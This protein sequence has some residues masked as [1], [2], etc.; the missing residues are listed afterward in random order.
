MLLRTCCER[1]KAKMSMNNLKLITTENFEE[2]TPCDFWADINNEY[3]LT[4]E[5]IGRALEYNNPSEAIK[6]IHQRHRERLDKF[7]CLI[8]SEVSRGGQTGTVD[9]NGAIQERTFYSRKGVMEICRWSRQPKADEFMDWCWDIIDGLIAKSREDNTQSL[10]N[11]IQTNKNTDMILRTLQSQKEINKEL[12][13]KIDRL[14]TL[15]TTIIPMPSYS[16][17]KTEMNKKIKNIASQIGNNTPDGI[18]S[19]YGDIYKIMRLDY[20]MPV[21]QY[22]GE[23]M[24]NHKEATNPPAID[25]VKEVPEL[26]QLFEAIVNNYIEIKSVPTMD[27]VISE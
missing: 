17:W 18:R 9:S 10:D 19:I 23:Y 11:I 7:S 1:I 3:F 21:E 25:I 4:R 16:E 8:K 14:E 24:I 12:I 6:K 22:K 26:K 27:S 5:Q 20:G 13:K 15:V 2:V